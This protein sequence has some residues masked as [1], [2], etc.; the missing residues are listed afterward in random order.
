MEVILII[1]LIAMIGVMGVG[2]FVLVQKMNDM[3]QSSAVDMVKAD[4]T[5][6]SRSIAGLQQTLG[7]KLER[8]ATSMQT[9]M[10]KQLGE[11]ARLVA[12]VT[13]RLTKLD[14]TN[15]RV[16]DV[17]DELK[18]LQNVLA[19][20]KQRGVLGEFYLKQIL[21]NMLPPGAFEL[22]YKMGEGL[23]VDAVIHLDD[24]ILPVDSKFSLENYNRMIEAKAED[25]AG[26]EKAFKDDLKK[27]I[28]E[29][30]KYINTRKGTLGQALMFIPSEAIYYDLLAN[31]VGAAG[32]NGRD[33]MQYA[34][35]DKKVTIV[36]PSTLSAMLQIISQGLNSLE[37]QKDTE[38]IRHN[39]EQLGKHLKGF[40][41]YMQKLGTSLGATVGHYNN[42]HKQLAR[43][44]KDVVKISGGA[45][46]IDPLLLDK[47]TSSSEG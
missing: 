21:E 27:R 39:V 20:P 31:K 25:R 32:V 35:V 24:K 40:D 38:V 37:I 6:L 41:G 26:L 5:E 17:A 46:S 42:A 14:E 7:D 15:R 33:L 23:I 4:V 47:P 1:L 10:Q 43:V 28:D 19:N 9:S 29:T 12:D 11:S 16:V 18:T 22:Q 3:R 8:N 34:A 2:L 36:G 45:E 13:Q 44:D 30:A